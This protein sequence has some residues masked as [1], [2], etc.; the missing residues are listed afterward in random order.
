MT[1]EYKR[2]LLIGASGVFGSRISQQL[3]EEHNIILTLA[4]R[5]LDKLEALAHNMPANIKVMTIDRDN[6]VAA[7]LKS[8]DMVIDAAGPFQ[9][10]HTM[11]IEAALAAECHYV[12]L[13]DGR[14]FINNI[15]RFDI[16][17]K[18]SGVAIICGA[19]S[20]PAL[21]HAVIDDIVADWQRI[22]NIK[23]GI[24]PG[25]KA[26]R[27]LSVV[28]AILTYVGTPIR[29]FRNG[30]WQNIY[31]WGKT[32]RVEFPHIGKRWASACNT[33]EQDLLVMRYKP[34]NSAEFFAG[35]ELSIMHL[36][37][38]SLS[39]FVRWKWISSLRP[40]ARLLLWMAIKLLPFG[41]DKGAMDVYVD[42]IDGKS[43][44]ITSRWILEADANH[45]PFVP[46]LAA[47]IIAR[48]FAQG[49][50]LPLGARPCSG[51]IKM[52][53][54]MV[55]FAKLKIVTQYVE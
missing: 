44:P 31:G 42:G 24:Y 38:L 18:E 12:D 54:F 26:P 8:F 51:L 48:N 52:E 27:G 17:A 39:Y 30:T 29:V 53:E 46:T 33:P 2:I 6:I 9:S 7:D 14:E 32:H 16:I 43:Q 50:S 5:S 34:N 10:S 21:S 13:S 22:D 49:E 36:G 41:S 19:S 1:D 11:V 55:E 3:S 47:V 28:E 45:G 40:Y 25:N 20:I 35:M 23:I 4:G 15:S 37:L